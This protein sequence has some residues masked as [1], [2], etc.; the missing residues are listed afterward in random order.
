MGADFY[1][2]RHRVIASIL[3]RFDPDFLARAGIGFGGG[4]RIAME[5]N[6][7]RE[8]SDI[9]FLCPTTASYRAVRE[10]VN[11]QGLGRILRYPLVFAREVRADR[12][13][14]RTAIEHGGHVIKLEFLS[15]EDWNLNIVDH[16]LFPVPVLD[17]SACFTT[18]LTAANDRG[19]AAPYKDVFDLLAMR[20]HWGDPPARAVAEAERHYG[21]SVVPKADQAIAHFLALPAT[22]KRKAAAALGIGLDFLERLEETPVRAGPSPGP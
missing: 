14:V 16:P 1:R 10:V 21:Q 12:Y 3:E 9:D 15:F 17:Q 11:N 2:E 19:L 8:S 18:K 13:G 7:Y 22:E 20:A 4:T 5:I 6:E